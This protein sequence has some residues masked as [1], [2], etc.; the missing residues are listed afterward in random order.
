MALA[1]AFEVVGLDE[2]IKEIKKLACILNIIQFKKSV[3]RF[4]VRLPEMRIEIG[5]LNMILS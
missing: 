4:P 1:I 2:F 3:Y 5:G